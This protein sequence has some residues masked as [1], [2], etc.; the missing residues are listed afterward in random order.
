MENF[1]RHL[2]ALQAGCRA[3]FREVYLLARNLPEIISPVCNY[4]EETGEGEVWLEPPP[5]GD[6]GE[7][8]ALKITPEEL[9]WERRQGRM[10]STTYVY[11]SGDAEPELATTILRS[12]LEYWEGIENQLQG[13]R[14]RLT[15]RNRQIRD[16]RRQLRK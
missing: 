1:L 9:S 15:L 11:N 8:Q 4:D 5:L 13:I 12:W 16:L 14:A 2:S 6:Y 7:G 10:Q 3:E